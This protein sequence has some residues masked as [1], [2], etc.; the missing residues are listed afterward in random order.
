[1][2][3]FN[4]LSSD[5]PHTSS[6]SPPPNSRSNDPSISSITNV[7]S[8][9]D[10]LIKTLAS[11]SKSL[12]EIYCRYL[13]QFASGLRNET[14][15]IQ[16][17]ALNFGNRVFEIV[18][19]GKKDPVLLAGDSEELENL[20][21]S[22]PYSRFDVQIRKIQ[23]DLNTYC[24]EPENLEEYYRWDLGFNLDEKEWEIDDLIEENGMIEAIYN[25]VVPSRVDR[26]TFWCRYFYW[27]CKIKKAEKA[28]AR[29]VN[30]RSISVEEEKEEEEDEFSS[31]VDDDDYEEI[32]GSKLMNNSKQKAGEKYSS[33]KIVVKR[34]TIESEEKSL[35][36]EENKGVVSESKSDNRVNERVHLVDGSESSGSMSEA[37]SDELG[38]EGKTENGGSCKDSYF[39]DVSSQPS[40]VPEE[41]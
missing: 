20:K 24:E 26:E 29:L 25:E 7:W 15:L 37:R 22:R 6:S 11:K 27:V 14:A 17:F 1:M 23:C 10:R 12:V 30:K 4:S 33:E 8:F 36:Q 32:D 35:E 13:K 28:R 5:D 31:D 41:E 19:H 9:G 21:N 18:C 38:S 3:F 2:N 39:S 34:S 40:L 16:E